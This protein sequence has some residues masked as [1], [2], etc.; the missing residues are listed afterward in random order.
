M[1]LTSLI[2][3]TMGYWLLFATC[4]LAAGQQD[5]RD[6]WTSSTPSPMSLYDTRNTNRHVMTG[7]AGAKDKGKGNASGSRLQDQDAH[8]PPSSP[9][10]ILAT[11]YIM[12]LYHNGEFDYIQTAKAPSDLRPDPNFEHIYTTLGQG[13]QSTLGGW[14]GQHTNDHSLASK[15]WQGQYN[16]PYSE[17]LP[18]SEFEDVEPMTTP[19]TSIDQFNEPQSHHHPDSLYAQWFR[20]HPHQHMSNAPWSQHLSPG[21]TDQYA[22]IHSS[23]V[24][25]SSDSQGQSLKG[26]PRYAFTYATVELK[27]DWEAFNR[28]LTQTFKNAVK[29]AAD[30]KV[31]IDKVVANVQRGILRRAPPTWFM[32]VVDNPFGAIEERSMFKE[33]A[34]SSF[35]FEW[36]NKKRD[37]LARAR[38]GNEL[39][40][41]WQ[42]K[43]SRKWIMKEDYSAFRASK[44][45]RPPAKWF[46]RDAKLNPINAYVS[47]KEKTS[48]RAKN[49][50]KE[51]RR[52]RNGD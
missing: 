16:D 19:Q 27:N 33:N 3:L 1:K 28:M 38:G 26:C 42:D 32:S 39:V 24:P 11:D 51:Q 9:E 10:D 2:M 7:H 13:E 12:E 49:K 14:N 50:R 22:D 25:R 21:Q 35:V 37:M 18:W 48:R 46:S 20:Q 17:H 52:R 23:R 44:I 5:T 31:S 45:T 29:K 15:A 34:L 6:A 47:E 40:Y 36:A 41:M 30:D 4:A 8:S 43:S